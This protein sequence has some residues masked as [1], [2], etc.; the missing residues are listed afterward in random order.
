MLHA[1]LIGLGLSR[2]QMLSGWRAC[3]WP[4]TQEAAY[5][6]TSL[7]NHSALHSVECSTC[8][9]SSTWRA[10]PEPC[11]SILLLL[12]LLKAQV[13][14]HSLAF[15]FSM[16]VQMCSTCQKAVLPHIS[17]FFLLL[18]TTTTTKSSEQHLW[19]RDTTQRFQAASQLEED[20]CTSYVAY[21]FTV[22]PASPLLL[23]GL[24]TFFFLFWQMLK[25]SRWT[26]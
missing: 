9:P 4:S 20:L 21:I 26:F 23:L 14:V 25:L 22:I 11:C 3:L 13:P 8:S 15:C 18:T 10:A 24:L 16:L 1:G 19:H 7:Q 12:L 17:T 5:G 2:A 6:C